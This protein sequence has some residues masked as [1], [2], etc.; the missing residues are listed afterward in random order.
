M[1]VVVFH[2]SQFFIIKSAFQED[3]Y[4]NFKLP[5][6]TIR[7]TWHL[8]QQSNIEK[9]HSIMERRKDYKNQLPN[10]INQSPNCSHI[11]ALL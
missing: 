1:K 5:V 7:N 8:R 11:N 4:F 10:P 9:L 3:N 2:E 6:N